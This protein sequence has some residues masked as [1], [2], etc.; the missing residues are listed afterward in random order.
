M[1]AGQ[2]LPTKMKKLICIYSYCNYT[3][4]F[5]DGMHKEMLWHLIGHLYM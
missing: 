1:Q 3:Y 2:I 4:N 5:N